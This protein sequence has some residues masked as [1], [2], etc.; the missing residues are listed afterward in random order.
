[1]ENEQLK[2]QMM[3]SAN[4]GFSEAETL[5]TQEDN[6]KAQE[7][8][9]HLR[10]LQ[11]ENDDLK[12]DLLRSRDYVQRLENDYEN[13]IAQLQDQIEGTRID[14][15]LV[16]RLQ[17]EIESMKAK[18][19]SL[20]NHLQFL[21]KG[22]VETE[23]YRLKLANAEA[24]NKD[25]HSHLERLNALVEKKTE[26]LALNESSKPRIFFLRQKM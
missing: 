19:S 13:R 2:D 10:R 25:L 15:N 21:A 26:E 24:D 8:A 12:D 6:Q 3:S 22:N 16:E 20:E 23:N 4:R 5:P 14:P 7:L 11:Q 1:M 18:N 9:M 17:D